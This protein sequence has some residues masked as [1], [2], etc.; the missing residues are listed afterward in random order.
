MYI[1]IEGEIPM[2]VYMYMYT[3]VYVY[4]YSV[5]TCLCIHVTPHRFSY[6]PICF[7]VFND[8]R[9]CYHLSEISGIS[10]GRI[11]HFGVQDVRSGTRLSAWV[12][13]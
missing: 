5:P 8:P 10:G 2:C 12:L 7:H 11:Q 1:Y 3:C 9:C 6:V 4:V 13:G